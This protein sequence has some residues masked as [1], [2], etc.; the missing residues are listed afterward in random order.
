MTAVP[1][2]ANSAAPLRQ[3][4]IPMAVAAKAK[5]EPL[6]A[7]RLRSLIERIACGLRLVAR[8]I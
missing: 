7:D 6:A 3:N 5:N 1:G 2:A 8:W 4:E